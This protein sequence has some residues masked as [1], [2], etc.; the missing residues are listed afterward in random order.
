[1]SKDEPLSGTSS[2]FLRFSI[3]K[4]RCGCWVARDQH[5]LR[6]GLFV[7]RAEA[8]RF[9]MGE[10][11]YRPCGVVMVA[12]TIELDMTHSDKTPEEQTRSCTA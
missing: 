4:N 3:G 10:N 2:A 1:M 7:S 6:G 5:G 12:D 9:A 8:I 11:G